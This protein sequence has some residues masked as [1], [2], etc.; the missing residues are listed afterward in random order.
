MRR[1]WFAGDSIPVSIVVLPIAR[2]PPSRGRQANEAGKTTV[3][4]G[5]D[6]SQVVTGQGLETNP[7]LTAKATIAADAAILTER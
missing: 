2:L 5:R 6:M 7:Q 4:G 1:P 3:G